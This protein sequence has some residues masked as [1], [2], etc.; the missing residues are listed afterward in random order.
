M[1][2]LFKRAALAFGRFT[3]R[4]TRP[5]TDAAIEQ[6]TLIEPVVATEQASPGVE[7]IDELIEKSGQVPAIEEGTGTPWEDVLAVAV[8]PTPETAADTTL[9]A[10][11]D[12]GLAVTASLYEA[13]A[14]A[15][16]VAT[17]PAPIIAATEEPTEIAAEIPTETP[18]E[19]PVTPVFAEAIITPEPEAASTPAEAPIET[20]VVAAAVEAPAEPVKAPIEMKPE[21]APAPAAPLTTLSELYDL[22]SSEAT[23]RADGTLAVYERLLAATREEL[24]ASHRNN[25][26][27]WSVGGVMTAVA[28]FGAIWSSG[29]FAATH[30]ELGSLRHQVGVAQ[31]ASAERDQLRTELLRVKETH[32]RVEIDALKSRLDQALAASAERD[33]LSAELAHVRKDRDDVE[34]EL[35]LARAAATTQPVSDARKFLEKTTAHTTVAATAGDKAAGAERPDVWS[36]LLNGRD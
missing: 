6:M 11:T 10:P 33:R 21:P 9:P 32:A 31:Q 5:E 28:V 18:A 36:S 26:V 2:S 13:P 25:R 12:E 22:I 4:R 34:S 24:E 29:E 15:A 20:P 16:E 3:G 17:E 30:T 27:A 14:D 7:P 1:A 8:E 23:K 19:T 35:R